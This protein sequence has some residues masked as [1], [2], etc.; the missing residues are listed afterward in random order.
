MRT[1]LTLAV[2]GTVAALAVAAGPAA[3][4]D[5]HAPP[6]DIPPH[7]HMLVLGAEV[8]FGA[9]GGPRLLEYSKCID[10]AAN[11]TLPLGSQ[12]EHV[13]FGPAGVA[14]REN[15]GH[16]V[17]PTAPAFN[18]PWTDCDSFLAFMGF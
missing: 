6:P 10:L 9:P 2:A 1:P 17:V 3:L 18:L 16:L 8:D 12:H 13:H 4:A 14:L 11:R 5:G 7:P 15:A